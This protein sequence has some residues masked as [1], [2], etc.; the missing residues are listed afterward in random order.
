[1]ETTLK[2]QGLKEAIAHLSELAGRAQNVAPIARDIFLLCQ[3]D[4]DQRFNAAPRTE[5]GGQ[6]YGGVYWAPLSEKYI[7]RNPRRRGGQLLRDSGEL[8]QSYG[9]GGT[10][11]VAIARPDQIVF[12]S[13]LPKAGWLANR[14]GKERPQVYLHPELIRNVK[15][16]V[17]LYVSGA[18]DVS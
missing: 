15:N 17:E 11:N 16:A 18:F 7:N 10:G 4:V 5:T 13:N 2:I 12:G 3:A 6:T 8:M 14:K 1:M 9:I